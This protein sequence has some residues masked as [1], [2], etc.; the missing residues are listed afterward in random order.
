[1]KASE[2]REL[3]DLLI[4]GPDVVPRGWMTQ[5][6][7]AEALGLT[8]N[9]IKHSVCELSRNGMLEVKKF[10]VKYDSI[11]MPVPHYRMKK[12]NEKLKTR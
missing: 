8:R 7:I 5:K 4:G 9:Q 2:L 1:M 12:K 10:K 11:L 3:R 6:Q